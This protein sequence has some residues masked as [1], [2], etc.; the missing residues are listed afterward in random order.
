MVSALYRV[1]SVT[2]FRA[3]WFTCRYSSSRL[4][5]RVK[6]ATLQSKAGIKPAT[7]QS[8]ADFTLVI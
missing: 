8:K 7:L 3:I 2:R 5:C 6:M 1:L 4:Y